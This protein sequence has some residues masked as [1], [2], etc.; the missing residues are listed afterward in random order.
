MGLNQRQVE[1]LQWIA[2]GTPE[3]E[4]PDWTHRATAKSLQSRGLVKVRGRGS[5]WTAV[6]TD[7]GQRVL[8]GGEPTPVRSAKASSSTRGRR[9]VGPTSPT[10][11]ERVAVDP[12]GLISNLV[13]A[14]G[15]TLRIGEPD[16]ET[17][18]GYRRALAAIPAE[19]I[20]TGKR[21]THT[22]RDKGDLV[23]RLVDLPEP[24]APG[25]EVPVPETA[26]PEHS[27]VNWLA[28]NPEHL[29]V[30]EPSRDRALRIIQGLAATL[31]ARGHIV[32]RPRPPA[33]REPGRIESRF[34]RDSVRAGQA[35]EPDPVT[36]ELTVGD[37][38][39]AVELSE[40]KEKVR[41]VPAEEAAKLKYEWQRATVVESWEFNG[42][43]ALTI[44]GYA[45][46][47]GWADR[48]R[49][50]LESR[51]SRFV[52]SIEQVAQDRAEAQQRDEDAKRQRRKEWEEALPKARAMYLANLNRARLD[53]QLDAFG[54]AG[55]LRT[56][57]D[58]VAR[59][60]TT[61]A[62][63]ER[64]AAEAWAGWICAEA[65][66]H[67]P[68]LQATSLVYVEPSKIPNWELDK[69]MP[70]GFRASNPP[71]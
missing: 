27:L 48:R 8:A 18:A 70:A 7:L 26:D 67:D 61:L 22:G 37:Q 52:T 44:T 53:K 2:D 14:P 49:W 9:A 59:R 55:Q 71:D 33:A 13:A 29:N 24:V 34:G 46:H 47:H 6:I 19:L 68:T 51:L 35:P 42:R 41:T 31:S 54:R 57:A 17:R 12:S 3:R 65:D 15:Q 23:I 60:A 11:P 63:E 5:A 28:R 38:I 1:I 10:R 20:P 62:P 30:A 66:R 39:L 16:A 32:S 25:P 69:Y 64:V 43:L 36:F 56:Y 40:E 58:A 45:G 50:T 21:V 4:W